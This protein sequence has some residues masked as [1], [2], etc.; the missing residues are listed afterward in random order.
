MKNK[1]F[2][3]WNIEMQH[4]LLDIQLKDERQTARKDAAVTN[5]AILRRFCMM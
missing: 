1:D 5:G 3:H 2:L 4:R